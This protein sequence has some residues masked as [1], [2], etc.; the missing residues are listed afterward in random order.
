MEKT[1]RSSL[2]K[3]FQMEGHHSLLFWRVFAL[4]FSNV[5][6]ADDKYFSFPK[7]FNLSLKIEITLSLKISIPTPLNGHIRL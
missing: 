4:D 6:R 3:H 7:D 5:S 2:K 1:T